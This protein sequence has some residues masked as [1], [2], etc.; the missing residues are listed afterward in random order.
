VSPAVPN[1]FGALG[2][3][4]SQQFAVLGFAYRGQDA[5]FGYRPDPTSVEPDVAV[6][7]RFLAPSQLLL[8]IPGLGEGALLPSGASGADFQGRLNYLGYLALGGNSHLTLPL[9]KGATTYLTSTGFGSWVS[10][11]ENS[12]QSYP[13]RLIEFVYG[14]PTRPDDVP[15]SGSAT[16]ESSD[17]NIGP[18]VVDFAARRVTGTIAAGG[19]ESRAYS[20]R[21]V[22]FTPDGT[23][24][25]ARLTTGD[26]TLEGSIDVRF[27]GTAAI[28][29]MG[30]YRAPGMEG[31]LPYLFAAA[32]R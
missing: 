24:F 29:L 12:P 27:T 2:Q 26:P 6:A 18:I 30:R 23:G 11:P 4:S 5:G 14:V 28:E 16:Y 22:V 7:L 19:T 31:N 32:K 25:Q 1:L 13:F 9:A 20:I 15:A 3:T 10:P 8:T 21:D 17:A